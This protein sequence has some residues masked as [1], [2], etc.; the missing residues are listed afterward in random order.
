MAWSKEIN[1]V[2]TE[3]QYEILCFALTNMHASLEAKG[4]RDEGG[5]NALKTTCNNMRAKFEESWS[6]GKTVTR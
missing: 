4:G 5:F 3:S 6:S 1:I 2:L